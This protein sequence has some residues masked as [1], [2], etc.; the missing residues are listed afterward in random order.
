MH[1][2]PLGLELPEC[3]AVEEAC[4]HEEAVLR[5]DPQLLRSAQES[6]RLLRRRA[7]RQL[8]AV[9]QRRA[10]AGRSLEDGLVRG[11]P[12]V[13]A[14]VIRSAREGVRR[15]RWLAFKRRA[16]ATPSKAEVRQSRRRSRSTGG[17]GRRPATRTARA[18]S[19]C[20][21]DAPESASPF[22]RRR[23]ASFTAGHLRLTR[24]T[25]GGG[26]PFRLAAPD[27]RIPGRS[28]IATSQ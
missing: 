21:A 23:S 1:R 22:L 2:T 20:A 27:C 15:L 11:D 25:A 6:V 13:V 18:S 12:Q 26:Q 28:E 10:D 7:A 17:A 3:G 14:K 5:A 9:Q 4:D 8:P 16:T 19:T 24:S